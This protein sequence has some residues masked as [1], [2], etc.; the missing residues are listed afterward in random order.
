MVTW[1]GIDDT[2]APAGGCTTFVLT[3]VI[4]AARMVGADLIGEPR[5]VRLNPNIPWKT[6]GNAA[7]AARFGRGTGQRRNAGELP[8]GP[9]HY[10]DRGR[11]LPKAERDRLV[12]AAWEAVR[13]SSRRGPRTDP[14]MVASEHRLPARLYWEAVRTVVPVAARAR[15][16]G[17]LGAEVRTVGSPRGLV[18]ASSA[19]AWPSRRVTWELIAY[20]RSDRLA[21]RREVDAESIRAAERRFPSLFLCTDPHTRRI[22][23]TPH[24]PCPILFGLRSTRRGPLPRALATVVSEPIDRWVVF[25]TNQAT[26]DHLPPG[27]TPEIRPYEPGR[28]TGTL[29]SAP[30][31]LRGGHVRFSLLR[32]AGTTVLCMVFEPSKTLS[33][34]ARGLALG[35]RLSVWGGRGRDATLRV[36]GIRILDAPARPLGR[37]PPKCPECGRTADS[38]GT[39]RGYRCPQC[40]RR[41]PPEAGIVRWELSRFGPGTYHPTPSARRHLHP[42]AEEPGRHMARGPL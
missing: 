37:T 42:L 12:D 11:P 17:A 26:G 41:F 25:R 35:D 27:D 6:R 13:R 36:E 9:L 3:E 40:R 28:A 34:V 38:M 2:D 18:G 16:L 21:Q 10:Y 23:V 15:A 4:R 5:L 29:A 8:E 19:I 22:L 39:G 24:T 1:I 31:R 7:L 14:A 33:E 30:Q 32:P 20:R